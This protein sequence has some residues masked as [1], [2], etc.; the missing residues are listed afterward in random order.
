M[1][2]YWLGQDRTLRPTHRQ[3][4]CVAYLFP[5]MSWLET[6]TVWFPRSPSNTVPLFNRRWVFSSKHLLSAVSTR[7]T[8]RQNVC[9]ATDTPSECMCR[10]PLPRDVLTRDIN[11]LVS[12]EPVKYGTPLQPSLSFLVK[13]PPFSGMRHTTYKFFSESDNHPIL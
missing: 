6:S 12:K 1:D 4:V 11:S 2:V 9:V 3:N 10:V 8:H 13:T 5:E 7:P